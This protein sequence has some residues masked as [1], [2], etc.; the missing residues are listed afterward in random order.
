MKL[1]NGLLINFLVILLVSCSI[2]K[3]ENCGKTILKSIDFRGIDSIAN[4]KCF[5][6][7]FDL[8]YKYPYNV[9]LSYECNEE[10]FQRQM[11]D[12]NLINYNHIKAD[13]LLC[14]QLPKYYFRK[15]FFWNFHN[16]NASSQ[17]YNESL[18][19]PWWKPVT[20]KNEN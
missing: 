16:L 14:L 15:G 5:I 10:I 20:N 12:I 4:V 7:N 19:M 13:S 17:G 18:D 9:Y 6:K 11:K 1:D 3:E 8:E 2:E